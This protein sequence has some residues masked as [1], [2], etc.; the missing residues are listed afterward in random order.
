MQP[1]VFIGIDVSKAQL[2]VATSASASL[3]RYPNKKGG[4]TRLIT[5]LHAQPLV[6]VVFEAGSYTARLE[7]AMSD[8]E[9]P[10]A[11]INPRRVRDFARSDGILAKTDSI[12]AHVLVSF[13]QQKNPPVRARPDASTRAVAA[14]LS[15]LADLGEM[16]V[17][18]S[19]RVEHMPAG[20][21]TRIGQHIRQLKK[22]RA[23]MLKDIN[24][25]IAS[26]PEMARKAKLLRSA[27]GVGP[28]LSA[29]L[30][31]QLPELG[32]LR[33]QRI[34]A[35]AGVAPFNR[36][37]GTLRGRRTV[38]GGRAAV[39]RVLFMG[40]LVSARFNPAIKPFYERLIAAGKPAKVALTACMRKL[41]TILNAMLR[42]GVAWRNVP[43]ATAT[44][45]AGA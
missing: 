6:M 41:L 24:L 28:I 20:I 7:D 12:D 23:A 30:L 39:R 3:R 14:Q 1:T 19:N 25:A 37:S 31:A 33:R 36:D 4:I 16:I 27:P 5:W 11:R 43:P 22:Q 38:W 29:T 17:M 9:V 21:K 13:G 8:A 40:A 18:E 42:E 2:D 44:A 35:L 45:G 34:A 32:T 26:N 15:R 10:Y